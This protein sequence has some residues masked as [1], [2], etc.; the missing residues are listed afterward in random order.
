MF[1]L[2]DFVDQIKLIRRMGSL[3]DLIKNDSQP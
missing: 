1:T 2:E 3:N